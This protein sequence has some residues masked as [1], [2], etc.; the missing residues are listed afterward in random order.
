MPVQYQSVLAEH[1][2]VRTAA[3]WFDVTHLGRFAVSGDKSG[4]VLRRL[5]CNDVDRLS[6]GR[7]HYTMSLNGEGGI[8][9]DIVIWRWDDDRWWVLPN[10]ANYVRIADM[11]EAE[12]VKVHR[13]Q[14]ET[15]M[16]AV[17]GPNAPA[18]L[19][20]VFGQAPGRF[21]TL[22]TE[23]GGAPAWL[24]GTGYT[25]EKGGEV[26]VPLATGVEL[27]QVLLEAGVKA[28]GLG[29][30]DTLRLE[31]GLPL[32]GQDLD[33]ATTPLEAGFEWV[34]AWDHDFAGK[35]ALVKQREVGVGK[36]L[37]GFTMSG[38]HIPRHEYPLRTADAAGVVTSGNWSPVLGCGIGLGYLS[39]AVTPVTVEVQIRDSWQPGTV[40]EPPFV[41]RS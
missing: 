31:A 26:C 38:R 4:D 10:A 37:L 20:K 7:T 5:F 28:C 30:R 34:V 18:A 9:D 39:P 19:K 41:P 11:V 1:Q 3:G 40:V 27:V 21:R 2:A 29:S 33:E 22:E 32:W 12:G 14:E 16:V 17:Q 13:L 6:P 25:G 23:F 35:D 15:L 8:I 36:R 24:A